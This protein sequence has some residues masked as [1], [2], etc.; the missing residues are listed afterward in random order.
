MLP[1]CRTIVFSRIG[2]NQWAIHVPLGK[3][4]T[5]RLVPVDAFVCELVQRLRFFR[6]FDPL[7]A[8]GRLLARP[9]GK[10]TLIQ[11]L[12]PYLHDVAAAVGIST[13]H[14]SAPTPAHICH[15][16]GPLRRKLARRS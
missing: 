12:R 11:Q 16:D 10:Q 9:S 7:P 13:P 2:P 6:S 8:D 5:E 4:K 3:L 1:T 15:R 14:R